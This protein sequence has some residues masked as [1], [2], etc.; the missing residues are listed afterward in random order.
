MSAE[1]DAARVEN[2][3]TRV[4]V[5]A[6]KAALRALIRD[7]RAAR[8]AAERERLDRERTRALL[9]RL[10]LLP[11][12][13]CVA[14]YLSIAPEPDT[15]ALCA[16]LRRQGIRVLVPLLRGHPAPT[17][18]VLDGLDGLRPGVHGIPEP[19]NPTVV[20][21][22]DADLVICSALAAT[23]D[24]RR[25]GVGGGW[26]DRALA[27]RRDAVPAW[28]LLNSDEVLADLPT[29]PH[30]VALDAVVTE[31]GVRGVGEAPP[32]GT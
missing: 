11:G 26:F 7:R 17:W 18:A 12:L 30:D 1:R 19:E 14:T 29:Q 32:S 6:A 8:G 13:G 23:P 24:G 10:G 3:G 4:D 21:L 31:R 27:E 16:A 20:P 28:G 5:P 15:L 22:R 2:A 25:L 9:D